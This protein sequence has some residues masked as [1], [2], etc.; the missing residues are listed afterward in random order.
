MAATVLTRTPS[1]RPSPSPAI[2]RIERP[3]APNAA[4]I[5]RCGTRASDP[6]PSLNAPD[7]P[8]LGQLT[9]TRMRVKRT[10]AVYRAGDPFT[11]LYAIRSGFF[12]SRIGLEDGRDHVTGFHMGGEILGMD[13]IG[14]NLHCADAIALEDSEV[15]IIPYEEIEDAGLQHQLQKVMSRELVRD[16]ATLTL[17]GT[18][19]AEERVASF[20]IN[21]SQRFVARGLSAVEFHLRMT[22]GDI[23][24]Y[25]GL[26]LE[27]VSRAFSRFH[28]ERLIDVDQRHVWILDMAGLKRIAAAA[29][30]M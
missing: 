1:V 23:G 18:M 17:L 24:S 22:R 3:S 6:L 8:L 4:A 12:K 29:G 9:Y 16:C 2:P 14:S 13:G 7:T 30:R 15:F 26:S 21:L 28:T 10:T 19:N 25:L 5:A 11:A 20:L 27:T